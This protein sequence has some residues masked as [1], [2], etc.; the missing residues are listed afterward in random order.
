MMIGSLLY[1]FDPYVGDMGCSPWWVTDTSSATF[2]AFNGISVVN[3]TVVYAIGS[4]LGNELWRR[5][6]GLYSYYW[7][8]VD[9][10]GNNA[11]KFTDVCFVD[12]AVGWIVGYRYGSRENGV[13]PPLST[14][15]Y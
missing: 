10:P 12:P 6:D 3:D 5:R 11:Y 8:N 9:V 1:A 14:L 13:S 2:G 7:Q 4:N 15:I